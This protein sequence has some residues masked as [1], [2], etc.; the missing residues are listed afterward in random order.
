MLL[1]L[2]VIIVIITIYLALVFGSAGNPVT[3]A[4]GIYYQ[5]SYNETG[6]ERTHKEILIPVMLN[7]NG[8][9]AFSDQELNSLCDITFPYHFNPDNP[10]NTTYRSCFMYDLRYKNTEYGTMISIKP[11]ENNN[12]TNHGFFINLKKENFTGTSFFLSPNI[13]K[14]TL[15]KESNVPVIIDN[16]SGSA[17]DVD[18]QLSMKWCGYDL[19]D[20][21]I[22]KGYYKLDDD[23]LQKT[24][25]V[26]LI[27]MRSFGDLNDIRGVLFS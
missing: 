8:D 2:F 3:G 7:E 21:F 23:P 13:E 18:I 27:K 26:V 25:N 11:V 10:E 20:P 6:A 1:I 24:G 5:F 4:K 22:C 19:N 17:S 15:F 16:S 14:Q 9:L 12:L